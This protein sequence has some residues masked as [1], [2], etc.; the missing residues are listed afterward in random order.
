MSFGD[1]LKNIRDAMREERLS[2]RTERVDHETVY[3]RWPNEN[4]RLGFCFIFPS[5]EE[6]D[7]FIVSE[8]GLA[9]ILEHHVQTVI[10]FPDAPEFSHDASGK[11]SQFARMTL[12]EAASK[13]RVSPGTILRAKFIAMGIYIAGVKE[14]KSRRCR[15]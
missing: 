2:L 7:A 4:I 12:E 8:M 9:E 15:S 5:L 3:L 6:Q 14:R 13:A 11:Q 1:A 10:L